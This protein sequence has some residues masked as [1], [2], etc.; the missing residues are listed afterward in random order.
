MLIVSIKTTLMS[1]K[2]DYCSKEVTLKSSKTRHEKNC[3]L[4][5]INNIS[6][7]KKIILEKKLIYL[8][9]IDIHVR[10]VDSSILK[11]VLII[12]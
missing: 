11:I 12:I 5:P 6:I 3:K 2:C 10:N 9:K 1:F 8:L 7:E 4:N